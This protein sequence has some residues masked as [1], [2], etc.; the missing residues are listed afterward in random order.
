MRSL[1]IAS[2]MS[3]YSKVVLNELEWFLCPKVKMLK[4]NVGE[5]KTKMQL[6]KEE[7]HVKIGANSPNYEV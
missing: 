7:G 6:G 2:R 4:I 1:I 3:K 5:K